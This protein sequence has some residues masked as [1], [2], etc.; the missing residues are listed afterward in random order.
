MPGEDR[1][2]LGWDKRG[3]LTDDI[4]LNKRVTFY[5]KYGD[6]IG[7]LSL[8]IAILCVLYFIA[9]CTKKRFYLN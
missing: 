5:A 8:Y 3:V 6:Y 2:R 1:E 4:S 7:R 9:Y